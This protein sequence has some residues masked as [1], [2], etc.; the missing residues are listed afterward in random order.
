MFDFMILYCGLEIDLN[1]K[2]KRKKIKEVEK[3]TLKGNYFSYFLIRKRQKRG[4]F[5]LEL[6]VFRKVLF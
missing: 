5:S 3:V 1:F 6:P 2:E 4:L